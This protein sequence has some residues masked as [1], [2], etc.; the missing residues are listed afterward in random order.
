MNWETTYK[1]L[2]SADEQ[3]AYQ[4]ELSGAWNTLQGNWKTPEDKQGLLT[5][6]NLSVMS[7]A[8]FNLASAYPSPKTVWQHHDRVGASRSHF[9]KV[10]VENDAFI[11]MN[12]KI[13]SLYKQ[14][15]KLR[16]GPNGSYRNNRRSLINAK[17]AIHQT[18]TKYNRLI[19]EK[20]SD[21]LLAETNSALGALLNAN[22]APNLTKAQERFSDL[23]KTLKPE[24]MQTRGDALTQ[25]KKLKQALSAWDNHF[26]KLSP[27]D[28]AQQKDLHEK[29]HQTAIN[30]ARLIDDCYKKPTKKS[31]G[32]KVREV[33]T[34]GAFLIGGIS[35]VACFIC[36]FVAPPLVLPL[37]FVGMVML[38]PIA[39]KVGEL[40]RNA[41]HQRAPLK[42]DLK[43]LGLHLSVIAVSMIPVQVL[44]AAGVGIKMTAGKLAGHV[45]NAGNFISTFIY[46]SI[47]GLTQTAKGLL[48]FKHLFKG[49]EK[50]AQ[51]KI[52]PEQAS[53]SSSL[54]A[55]ELEAAEG[56]HPGEITI[57][58]NGE[59]VVYDPGHSIYNSYYED[60]GSEAS[61]DSR[62]LSPAS[63]ESGYDSPTSPLLGK[64]PPQAEIP[65]NHRNFASNEGTYSGQSVA[66][67][68]MKAVAEKANLD[69]PKAL[70]Q[71]QRQAMLGTPG[72]HP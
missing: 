5:H 43:E 20:A 6:N 60:S 45:I 64:S 46:N 65:S 19:K 52:D 3:Q 51:A 68:M 36:A 57:N 54:I 59:P 23:A 62:P 49:P 7:D 30:A 35:S 33:A 21:T 50:A 72:F 66:D 9:D 69:D 41:F 53:E 13:D 58:K 29:C 67:S 1:G 37:A 47:G 16:S 26:K 28:K 4:A 17:E 40:L 48:D 38:Y 2:L 25:H 8:Q 18:Q 71:A 55:A 61:D 32:D 34:A 15:P 31:F 44:A 11:N 56:P 12:K 27:E 14:T 39:D 10:N 70:E 63:V 42:S 22:N 24:N